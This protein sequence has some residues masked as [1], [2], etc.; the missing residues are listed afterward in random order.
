MFVLCDDRAEYYCI[1]STI[2]I[3]TATILLTEVGEPPD[4]AEPHTEPQ[5]GEEELDR[6]VPG[7]SGLTR[8]RIHH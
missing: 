6:T 1:T 7:H 8:L 2:A 5:H 4:V 3:L